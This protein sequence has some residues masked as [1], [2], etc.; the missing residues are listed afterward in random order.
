MALPLLI[1]GR[2]GR[3]VPVKMTAG[4]IKN[5]AIAALILRTQRTTPEQTEIKDGLSAAGLAANRGV[6]PAAGKAAGRRTNLR[7]NPIP[8][9]L[10]QAA[11]L[12]AWRICSADDSGSGSVRSFRAVYNAD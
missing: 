2:G 7:A 12:M 5:A 4:T 10:V 9:P 3:A 1:V 11:L 8:G 6:N